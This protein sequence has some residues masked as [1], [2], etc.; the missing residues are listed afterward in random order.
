MLRRGIRM[1]RLPPKSIQI[2]RSTAPFGGLRGNLSLQ[3]NGRI[4]LLL[5]QTLFVK[6][7]GCDGRRSITAMPARTAVPARPIIVSAAAFLIGGSLA[8]PRGVSQKLRGLVFAGRS[9]VD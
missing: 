5:P 2:K 1:F 4:P 7:A 9:M 8:R 3:V 6:A